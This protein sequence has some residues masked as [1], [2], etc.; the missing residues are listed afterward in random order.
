VKKLV[1][2]TALAITAG[3]PAGATEEAN[4]LLNSAGDLA[5]LCG[6]PSEPAAIHMCEGYLLG[7]HHMHG[8][9][10]E[11]L[12]AKVYC[13][14]TDGSVTRDTAAHDFSAWVAATPDAA[15]MSA[16]EGVLHWAQITY[17]CK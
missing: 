17:P 7:I 5:A 8:A 12:G 4:F 15:A 16:R 10:D 14:P 2:A 3:S 13:L 6:A 1:C 11:A 9:I